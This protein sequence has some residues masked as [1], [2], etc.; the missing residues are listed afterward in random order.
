MV[1]EG[2]QVISIADDIL[3]SG[4]SATDTE[5]RIDYD[6][7]LIAVLVRFEQHH[8]KLNVNKMKFL[9]RKAAFMGHVITTDGLQ[10]N[11]ITV[12]AIV[13]IATPTDKQ[14]FRRF[15]GAINY[16][17]KFCPQLS[18]ITHPLRNLTKEDISFLW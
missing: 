3:I 6:R 2:L 15:L 10:P 1:L 8:V 14:G 17:S 9:V 16:L 7:N 11:P 12:Q 13:A 4:C 5:A 18:S